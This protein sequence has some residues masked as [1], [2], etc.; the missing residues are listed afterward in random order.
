MPVQF[1]TSAEGVLDLGLAFGQFFALPDGFQ[2][3]V[4]GENDWSEIFLRDQFRL[5]SEMVIASFNLFI[6]GQTDWLLLRIA[7]VVDQFERRIGE[8]DTI[9]RFRMHITPVGQINAGLPLVCD[10]EFDL[11]SKIDFLKTVIRRFPRLPRYP[12]F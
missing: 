9:A 6:D 8:R 7:D 1:V 3:G 5:R 2:G 11:V 4:V 10:A 12:V